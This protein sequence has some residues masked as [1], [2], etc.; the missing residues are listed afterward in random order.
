VPWSPKGLLRPVEGLLYLT[1][2]VGTCLLKHV[3][4]CNLRCS[5]VRS[6]D[7]RWLVP[8]ADMQYIVSDSDV[9]QRLLD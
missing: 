8:L 6:T 4:S 2:Y 1:F 5:A 7:C 3:A 9:T